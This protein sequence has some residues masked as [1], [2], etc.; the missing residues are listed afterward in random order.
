MRACRTRPSPRFWM[1]YNSRSHPPKQS[2][3]PG[4]SR[5]LRGITATDPAEVVQTAKAMFMQ[6]GWHVQGNVYQAAGDIHVT[7]AQQ[8][9]LPGAG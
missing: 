5:D 4:S 9:A 6:Q 3:A 1:P 7:L 2:R 8:P